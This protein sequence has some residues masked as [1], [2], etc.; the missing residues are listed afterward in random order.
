MGKSRDKVSSYKKIIFANLLLFLIL[1]ENFILECVN[2]NKK[3]Q[4]I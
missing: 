3:M 1:I 4:I 2:N